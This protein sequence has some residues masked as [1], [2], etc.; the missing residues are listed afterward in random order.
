VFCG[1]QGELGAQVQP[2]QQAKDDREHPVHL[3]GVA[4]VVAD[5]VAT[6]GLQGLPGDPSDQRTSDQLPGRD[7]LK[8]SA[9]ATSPGTT[10]R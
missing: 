8:V 10:R 3:A 7:L 9:P 1:V 6:G 2:E 4:Q 5:Q